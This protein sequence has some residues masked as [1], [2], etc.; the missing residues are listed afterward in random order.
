MIDHIIEWCLRNRLLT[1]LLV[2]AGV[3]Y[4]CYALSQTP[5]DAIPDLSENQVIVFADWMGRSPKEVE[6]QITYP[7]SVNLQGLAGVKAVRSSSEFNFSMINVIF[8]DSVD[9]YFARTRVLERLSTTATLLPEGVVPYLAPDATAL[10]Q[11]FWYT[12]EGDGRDLGELR[13]LQDWYVRYQLWAVPGVAQVSTVGGMPREWQVDVDPARLRAF[14]V[15]LGEVYGA[16]GRSNS[17]VGGRVVQKGNAEYIVR[18]VGWIR[19]GRDIEDTPV[20]SRGGTPIRVRDVATVQMGSEF[21][22]SVLEKG[23][24]EAV[25]GVVMMRYGENPLTV[26]RA[27]HEKLREL[28]PGLP[29]GVRVVP[30]YDRTRLIEEA[31]STVSHTVLEEMAVA[32]LVV[33]F[34]MWHLGASLI[35]CL[36]YPLAVLGAFVFMKHFGISSN[37]MSLSG[38]A[39]SIGVLE[40]QAVVLTDNA[41]HHLRAKF[42][43]AKVHGDT[44]D[45]LVEPC[46]EVGRPI[47]WGITIMVVSFLPVF[48]LTGME[49]KMFHPLAFTKTFALI[50]VGVLT[51]T[52]LPAMLPVL[53]KG[54]MRAE[55]SSWL[56]R[57]VA[58][59]YRPVLSW[60]MERHRGVIVAFVC[61][62]A[63]G[64]HLASRM[65]REFMPPLD[66][67][68]ILDMPVTVPRVSVTQ[69]GDDLKARDALL[70]AF[71][72]V[73]SVVG[74]AGR[75]DTPTDP[76]PL[77]MVETVINL[78]PREHWARRHLEFDDA[79]AEAREVIAGLVTLGVLKAVPGDAAERLANDGAMFGV[80][81][82]DRAVRGLV[83]R[84]QDDWGSQVEVALV[85]RAVLELADF[86]RAEGRLL[87]EPADSDLSA[88]TAALTPSFG[89]RLAEEPL[90][91]DVASLVREAG[92]GLVSAGVARGGSDLL[93][94]THGAAA[95]FGRSILATVLGEPPDL[96]QRVR[97]RVG[98]ERNEEW[99]RR[100][101]E[102][103]WEL[104]TFVRRAYPVAVA[105]A[106]VEV[107]KER[108]L[109]AR[110][111]EATD[112][113]ELGRRRAAEFHPFLR[114]KTKQDL[115]SEMDSSI[116]VPGWGN[117]WTQPI[118]NRIDMLAT[119]V[120]T[121]IG[122]KVFGRDL[123]EIQRV[124]DDV[125]EVLRGVPGAVDVFPDQSIGKGYV[126]VDIDRAKA[127]RYGI[128]VGD[129]QDV[130]EIAV[131]GRPITTTVMGRE[132]YPVRVRYAR[133]ARIDEESLRRTLIAAPGAMAGTPA[134]PGGAMGSGSM[135]STS[136]ASATGS[137]SGGMAA[138]SRSPSQAPA[139]SDPGASGGA[140]SIG[141]MQIPLSEVADVRVIEGPS[142]IKS[143]N[144]MLRNYVQLNVRE[145]D[146]VGFVEEAK[147]RVE[148]KVK[149][150]E[151]VH[152]EWSGQFEHQVRAKRT[153]QVVFPAVILLIF[154]ILYVTY[155]DLAHAVLMMLAIPGALA[156]G[157]IFQ[158]IMGFNFSV[159][160][161]VGY[162]ACFGMATETGIVML[163]YL[164]EAVARQGGIAKIPSTE[165]L[166]G[167][168]LDG[169]VRRLRPKLLSEGTTI[170][171]LAPMLWAT[172]TGAEIMRPMAAPVLGGILMADE[173]I[174][175]FLPVLFYWWEKRRWRKAHAND[176]EVAAHGVPA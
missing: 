4:G 64:L 98:D 131:G 123:N 83:L 144:G 114:V 84:R 150:P 41:M 86:L 26:T 176:L 115:L 34:V 9:F 96:V 6:D 66:E 175:V 91:A 32:S 126:E 142:M 105:E 100:V 18:G 147:R 69:A 75:A 128:N 82:Y 72:E 50:T 24:R 85:R 46:K 77:D 101:S 160:V 168:V 65:G 88:I 8:D 59:I 63:L 81:A 113:A 106:V 116:R 1:L 14:G 93:V 10:G 107:A 35:V 52:V 159:A 45:I 87:R 125:A 118:I 73:E 153:L 56:I 164:R 103:R 170:L 67:G 19:D 29:E 12:V 157:V 3:V 54:R 172:G 119:G 37:I 156:G 109:L 108:N 22:R 53:L 169:A 95:T 155:H 122:V 92:A 58:V 5:V 121:M 158:S 152:L 68:S 43:D 2:G 99:E 110:A 174:D 17:A 70:R 16:I 143:E 104:D 47:F 23:G 60:L 137:M 133:D 102:L 138:S 136:G 15:S 62:L 124:S 162:I 7:L 39:I 61:I 146:I 49:G 132:R 71:P 139:T 120:R 21:R 89:A 111:A 151:G 42:G 97:D 79:S 134:S 141:P 27:I 11:I 25:G 171:G 28:A 13:A 51:I 20:G 167:L 148:E 94:E 166:R 57:S 140:S 127:A 135:P 78:R 33:L 129:V 112:L 117:I 165:V 74:K 90:L 44:R 145:R 31:I 38:I 80:E 149:L 154:V 36:T 55:E 161:W 173:V 48:A 76:S 30:F 40:D 130:I 163:V